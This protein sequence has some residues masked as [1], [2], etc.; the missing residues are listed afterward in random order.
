MYFVDFGFRNYA[1]GSLGNYEMEKGFV[2]QNFIFNNLRDLLKH[3]NIRKDFWRTKQGGE[4]DIVLDAFPKPIPIEVKYSSLNKLSISR[5]LRSFI[6]KYQP[7]KAFIINLS[8]EESLKIGKTVV[9]TVPFF[10]LA[11]VVS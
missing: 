1:L 5:S 9:E 8:L 7:Q 2:F 10:K 4:V 11:K 6:E 3:Q